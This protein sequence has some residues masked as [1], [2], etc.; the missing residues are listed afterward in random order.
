MIGLPPSIPICPFLYMVVGRWL[1]WT[2]ESEL[3]F[4]KENISIVPLTQ[5]FQVIPFSFSCTWEYH[6]ASGEL[7]AN[8]HSTPPTPRP[9]MCDDSMESFSTLNLCTVS[10]VCL[11]NSNPFGGCGGAYRILRWWLLGS[12]S[13]FR[14]YSDENEGKP[15]SQGE[16][17]QQRE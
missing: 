14:I 1:P 17:D 2:I 11:Y 16:I 5:L 15:K 8:T 6:T 13:T 7:S 12:V 10:S 4:R 3:Q 9:F